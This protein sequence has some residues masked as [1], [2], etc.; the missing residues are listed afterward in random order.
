MVNSILDNWL[1]L[2]THFNMVIKKEKCYTARVIN[3]MLQ[4][5]NNY[6][7]LLII[8]PILQEFNHLNMT[9][10]KNF[11]DIGKSY[12][13]ITGLFI[14]LT[15][16]VMKVSIVTHGYGNIIENIDNDSAYMSFKNCDFGIG[17]NQ[18][19]F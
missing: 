11:V 1:E 13:D 5:N 14:F 2:K 18:G 19:L 6:L 12:D 7:Y 16:K 9:F 10:Q 17:Y 8:R 3:E 4:D 15:K